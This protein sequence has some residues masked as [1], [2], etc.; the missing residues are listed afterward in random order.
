M[1]ITD[2]RKIGSY[3]CVR[4]CTCLSHVIPILAVASFLFP[5]V[6]VLL[7]A[8]VFVFSWAFVCM[9]DAIECVHFLPFMWA[10]DRAGFC[11]LCNVIPCSAP[12]R[13]A[14]TALLVSCIVCDVDSIFVY[15]HSHSCV[16]VR[17]ME[18]PQVTPKWSPIVSETLQGVYSNGEC[19]SIAPRIPPSRVQ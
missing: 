16:L 3:S 2:L 9:S 1:I 13:G 6:L 14:H 12:T 11:L 8:I 5:F 10:A 18:G 7:N 17:T 19:G 15:A 4:A